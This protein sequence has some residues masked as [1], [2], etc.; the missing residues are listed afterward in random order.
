MGID[1]KNDDVVEKIG[2]MYK[3]KILRRKNW[4]GKIS[5]TIMI[6]IREKFPAAAFWEKEIDMVI[7][8]KK[9]WILA[10]KYTRESLLRLSSLRSIT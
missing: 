2:L 9:N 5:Q 6:K 10:I 7:N 1:E 4:T 3:Q 8:E